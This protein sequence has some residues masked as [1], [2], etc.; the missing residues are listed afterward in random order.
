MA[1]LAKALSAAAGN[2][3]GTEGYVEDVFSTYLYDG[4]SSTNAIT[5]G[6]DLAGEGGLVWLKKRSGTGINVLND[7]ARGITNTLALPGSNPQNNLTSTA[8]AS[9]QSTG[10]TMQNNGDTNQNGGEYVSWSFRKQKGF[11]DCV[12]FST[13][14]GGGTQAISHNLGSVPGMIIIK[15]TSAT[16]S[17]LVWKKDLTQAQTSGGSTT[18]WRN[19]AVL[20]ATAA[21]TDWGSTSGLASEPSSTAVTLGTYYTNASADYVMYV[22]AEG[23][24]D[25]Q[26]F[27]DDGDQSIIKCGVFT[28]NG[29]T[30]V[31]VDLGW[32]PQ[33]VIA[34]YSSNTSDWFIMDAMRGMPAARDT[35]SKDAYLTTASSNA[36]NTTHNDI[37]SPL[38]NGFH[39]GNSW[40]GT[41][42]TVYIA[43][44][45]GPMKEPSA[46]TDVFTPVRP[47]ASG[48]FT[49][50][51]GFPTDLTINKGPNNGDTTYLGTRLTGIYSLNP[52]STAAASSVSFAF[53]FMNAMTLGGS[54]NYSAW[55]SW[56]FRRYPKVFDV[57]N[58]IG[59]GVNSPLRVINHN[60]DVVPELVII[61]DYTNTLHWGVGTKTGV[62]AVDTYNVYL[63]LAGVY[64]GASAITA[65]AT[66]L[67][68]TQFGGTGQINTAGASH[69]ALFFATLA[70]ISKVGT[71][72]GNAGY[73]VNVDCG[74]SGGARFILI[75]RTGANGIQGDWYVFD[76]VTGIA[77]GNEAYNLLNT[78]TGVQT[79]A[80]YIDPLASGFTVTSSAPNGLNANGSTYLF[81]AFA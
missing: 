64:S 59:N 67:T 47:S 1:K 72:S 80:D 55:I 22:F 21:F 69:L 29:S 7:T 76:T 58:Y 46:G 11:F 65:T 33:W 37:I 2:A 17:W 31:D 12:A 48:T 81:L 62:S 71:Y 24:T 39:A 53:D 35:A 13:T 15:K 14:G 4:N 74:F 10:F 75:K 60:L 20:D 78:T 42:P 6:L 25:D 40:W 27:G 8:V 50:V 52:T 61:K 41:T 9:V 70:G 49:A 3:G 36:E 23:G 38:A 30:G 66:T 73:A 54:G 5:N 63:N 56:N 57:V 34:K 44:R 45:R 18:W 16:Q 26:I 79:A 32:E 68:L 51:S 43:I 28:G 77:A 19:Y